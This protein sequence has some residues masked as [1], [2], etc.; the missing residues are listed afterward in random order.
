MDNVGGFTSTL[1]TRLR[2]RK[3]KKRKKEKKVVYRISTLTHFLKSAS[4][5]ALR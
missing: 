1:S 2:K 5:S 4:R 3:E